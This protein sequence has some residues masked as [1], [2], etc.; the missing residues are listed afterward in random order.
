MLLIDVKQDIYRIDKYILDIAKTK[1]VQVLKQAG[2]SSHATPDTVG[3]S[4]IG[5]EPYVSTLNDKHGVALDSVIDIRQQ[6]AGREL[7][8]FDAEQ[9]KIAAALKK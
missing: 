1:I 4:T 3:A 6:Q 7:A 9:A 8:T 5:G 2:S